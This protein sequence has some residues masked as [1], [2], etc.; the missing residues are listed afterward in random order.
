MQIAGLI[1]AATT[2]TAFSWVSPAVAVAGILISAAVGFI[3]AIYGDDIRG[4]CR[5]PKLV[6]SLPDLKGEWTVLTGRD[7]NTTDEAIYFHVLIR[8]QKQSRI[9]RDVEL[10]VTECVVSDADRVNARMPIPCPLPIKAR[11][12]HNGIEVGSAPYAYDLLRCLRSGRIELL[13]NCNRPNNFTAWITRKGTMKVGIEARGVNAVSNKLVVTF[14]WDGV[15]PKEVDGL[16]GHLTIS[17]DH[18]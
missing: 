14:T 8:N 1:L 6:I 18:S 17:L 15:F 12:G 2:D 5:R 7:G 13:L 9:A 3:I 11:R 16:G 4:I 10:Y